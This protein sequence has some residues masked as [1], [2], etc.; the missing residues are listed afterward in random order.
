MILPRRA[1]LS[2]CR[3]EINPIASLRG[4][5]LCSHPRDRR[6]ASDAIWHATTSLMVILDNDEDQAIRRNRGAL[7]F[8][9][10]GSWFPVRQP[11]PKL[12][13]A[14]LPLRP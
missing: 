12:C 9:A 3:F 7:I 4:S 11:T 6:R 13:P 5:P 1:R 14:P 8:C 2:D 10:H